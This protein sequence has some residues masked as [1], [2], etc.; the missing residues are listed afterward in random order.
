MSI[1]D[2]LFGPH[3]HCLLAL[4]MTARIFKLADEQIKLQL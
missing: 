4:E 1:M 3:K 2:R